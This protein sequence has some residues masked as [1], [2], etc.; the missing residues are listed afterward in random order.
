MLD[1]P[2]RFPT[3]LLARIVR[4]ATLA[5]A[6][7]FG[8]AASA[9]AP[10]T[11]PLTAAEAAIKVLD[12]AQVDALLAKPDKV[13]VLDV[14]RPE[15]LSSIG[16]F[17]V[18]LNIQNADLERSLGYIPRDRQIITVSNHAH[19]AI[20]AAALLTGKGFRVAGAAGVQ[21]YEAQGG[22]LSGKKVAGQPAPAPAGNGAHAN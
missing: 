7:T 6:L 2:K 3:P 13:L 12:R 20:R 11:P 5:A 22:T 21:D 8:V 18:F 15:E 17:P 9:Q 10:Q 16:S 4:S 19:R 1:Y 14:R